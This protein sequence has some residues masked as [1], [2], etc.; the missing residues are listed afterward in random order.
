M[1]SIV[2]KARWEVVK[3]G[4]LGGWGGI[5]NLLL[6]SIGAFS[7]A[8]DGLLVWAGMSGCASGMLEA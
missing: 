1:V 4:N 6:G 8:R 2:G 7:G 5:R 3:G